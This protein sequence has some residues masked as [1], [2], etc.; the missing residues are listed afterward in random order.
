MREAPEIEAPENG[1]L[2]RRGQDK[3][4]RKQKELALEMEMAMNQGHEARRRD[5]KQVQSIK[6]LTRG[7]QCMP[8]L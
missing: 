4:T 7:R 8:G 6:R 2:Q 5:Q 1:S 3:G